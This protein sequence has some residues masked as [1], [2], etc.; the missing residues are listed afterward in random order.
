MQHLLDK[1]F[2]SCSFS[3]NIFRVTVHYAIGV[4]LAEMINKSKGVLLCVAS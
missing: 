3:N 4:F 2:A 1:M